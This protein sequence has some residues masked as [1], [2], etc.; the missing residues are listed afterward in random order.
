[1]F[2]AEARLKEAE[3]A[4]AASGVRFLRLV[5]K[6]LDGAF[7]P[8]SVTSHLPQSLPSALGS[9]RDNNPRLKL[10][11]ADIDVADA[12]VDAAQ[13][14]RLPEVFLEGRGRIGRDVDGSDGRT[15]DLQARVVARWNLYR[16][17]IDRAN[18]Q[19]QIRRASEQRLVL[20]QLQRE[21]EE[22]VRIS[23]D[24]R[25]KQASLEG[26]LRRQAEENGRLVSSYRQ[27]F[28]VGQRELLDVLDAQNTRFNANVLAASAQFAA[29]FSDYQLLT[30]SGLLLDTMKTT[31]PQQS[32]AYA[33][34]E[35][36]VPPTAP[37]ET[38]AREPSRQTNE[39]P[40][41]LLAPLRGK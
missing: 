40:L 38:Y 2:A 23:W 27:Q 26:T 20:H 10:A 1:M 24:R 35:F 18:K 39:L 19:E 3:E 15:S 14:G 5:G 22:A 28:E 6:P 12:Q 25:L 9:A 31:P 13:G 11:R 29:L 4:L 36:K 21:V 41:D 30:A 7:L 16:G 17:G 33:R 37:T 32:A 34:T 8:K